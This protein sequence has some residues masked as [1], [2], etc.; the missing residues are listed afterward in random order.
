MDNPK[1]LDDYLA[2]LGI[3]EADE[4]AP[5]APPEPLSEATGT[6]LHEL[7]TALDARE[8]LTQFLQGL[9]S[10]IDP[11][12]SVTV[13]A[14]DNALE[15]EIQG[16]RAAKMAGRDGR[17]LGAIEV[18]AYAALSRQGYNDIR[19]RIDAG[20]F[21]RRYN[22]NLSR[23]AERLAVQV[24]KTGESHEMQPMPPAD[25]RVIHLALQEHALVQTES[26][27]EGHNRRLI[28]RPRPHD[29]S[30]SGSDETG[31]PTSQDDS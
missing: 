31:Q 25:R 22:E 18:L 8:T 26:V 6:A 15:A 28:I 12:L 29:S 21:R 16:E 20:G 17:I 2:G 3:S 13:N 27:G 7:P 14:A 4:S 1:N 23:M 9:L 5:P 24:A 11:E 10:R 19:V 30:P